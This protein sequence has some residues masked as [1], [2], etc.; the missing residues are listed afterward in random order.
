MKFVIKEEPKEEIVELYLGR[1]R[2]EVSL[3]ARNQEDV[4][5]LMTFTN[6]KFR[7]IESAQIDGIKTDKEG[8][9]EEV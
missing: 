7:R 3:F 1:E 2:D 6:G 9:I 4:K 5:V 8:R